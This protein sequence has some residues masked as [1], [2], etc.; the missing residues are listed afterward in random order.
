MDRL[1]EMEREWPL[2]SH[3]VVREGDEMVAACSSAPN[4]VNNGEPA[5]IYYIYVKDAQCLGPLIA[6]TIERCI[7]A[8]HQ[9]LLVDLIGKHRGYEADYQA[10]GF[11]WAAEW[12]RYEKRLD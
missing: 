3:L 7:Q 6:K 1:L 12:A 10:M 9:R 4:F 8:G 11:T 5:A 2:I